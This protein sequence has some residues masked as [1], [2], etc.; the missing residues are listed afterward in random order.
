MLVGYA[1]FFILGE[2]PCPVAL[3]K[4]QKMEGTGTKKIVL[5]PRLQALA[6]LVSPG[7]SF[8]DVGTD[9]GYLPLYLLQEGRISQGIAS[10]VHQGPLARATEMSACYKIPLDLRLC[11]GLQGISP[12]EIDTVAIAGMGGMTMVQILEAWPSSATWTGTYLLQ[13]MSTQ[14]DLRLWLNEHGFSILQERTIRE[15]NTLYSIMEIRLGREPCYNAGELLVGRQ[16]PETKDPLR[17]ALLDQWMEKIQRNR[18]ALSQG[19]GDEPR[20]RELKAQLDSLCAMRE[21]WNTWNI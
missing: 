5:T 2:R 7:S 17:G 3:R 15:G 9:H 10:D 14:M 8:A 16:R 13:P 18:K 12:D 11:N 4:E 19:Q 21:E 20:E 1:L 6:D